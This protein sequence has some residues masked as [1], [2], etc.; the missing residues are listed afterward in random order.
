M[1]ALYEHFAE[2]WKHILKFD[3]EALLSLYNHESYG[4]ELSA[5][6]GFAL[7]KQRLNLQV[8]AWREMILEGSLA[9]F[10]L[11]EDPNY[12][13]WWL[14]SCLKDLYKGLSY[15]DLL[16][17]CNDALGKRNRG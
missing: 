15:A 11:Y 9:K 1:A 2:P 3:D 7:G 4:T 16:G 8:T 12:P 10:E 5:Q 13:H 14:D 6:N 17:Y